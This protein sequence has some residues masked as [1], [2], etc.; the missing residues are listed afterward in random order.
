MTIH[1]RH[2]SLVA[3]VRGRAQA[4]HQ[5]LRAAFGRV[6]GQ[7]H[8][9]RNRLHAHALDAELEQGFLHE[10]HALLEGEAVLLG[11]VM[12][13]AHDDF[14][15]ELGG[16][17]NDFQVTVVH[18]VKGSGAQGNHAVTSAVSKW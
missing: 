3:V 8:A 15:E 12:G 14:I 9:R 6:L 10:P 16:P 5:H 17:G 2:G 18:G 7:Q 11:A 13:H 1:A 4:L